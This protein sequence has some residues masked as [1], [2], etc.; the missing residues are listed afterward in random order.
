MY[1]I[2]VFTNKNG[3]AADRGCIIKEPRGC[4]QPVG[5]ARG[6]IFHDVLALIAQPIIRVWAKREV[7]LYSLLDHI[8]NEF[9]M[10]RKNASYY[11]RNLESTG[12][13]TI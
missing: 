8:L 1:E 13:T 5:K 3:H 4:A 11:T 7:S 2:E 12:C 9:L 10:V 6:L